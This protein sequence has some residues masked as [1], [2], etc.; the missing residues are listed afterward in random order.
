VSP[1][2]SSWAARFP[3]ASLYLA[4]GLGSALGGTARWLFSEGMQVGFG[5]GWPW[6]TLFVNVTGSL[7][8]GFYA[9]L[10]APDGR[11]FPSPQ[12][13]H[14]V[15]TG[16]CGGYTTFSIFSLETMR[17]VGDGRL[18]AAALQVGVSLAGWLLAVWVGYSLA[19]KLNRL[20][21]TEP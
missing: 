19:V 1:T 16:L 10:S 3:V 15:M 4:V 18:A 11:L 8:I 14:F 12:Q 17:V 6:G 21:R 2:V 13:R 7:L 9:A 20:R 5:G